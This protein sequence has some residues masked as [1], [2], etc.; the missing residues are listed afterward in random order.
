M[1]LTH[2]RLLVKNYRDCF[3]FYR[4]V[5][6]FPVL[7]GDEESLYADFDAGDAKLA[8]FDRRQMA[9]A[10]GNDHLPLER[11][12]MDRVVIIFRVENVDETYH[13]LKEQGVHFVAEPTSR[14]AWRIRSAQFRDPDGTLIEINQGL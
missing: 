9:E 6:G 10:V 8:L 7:W 11:K 1:Q 5:L 3:L 14:E 13:G 4:D 2:T 12:A